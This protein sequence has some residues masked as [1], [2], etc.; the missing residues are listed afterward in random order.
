M[1]A[2][3]FDH[4]KKTNIFYQFPSI[5]QAITQGNA[6]EALIGK[7]KHK[8]F[9]RFNGNRGKCDGSEEKRE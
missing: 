5:K 9:I 1:K 2:L 8:K 4:L 3:N 6:R 7:F